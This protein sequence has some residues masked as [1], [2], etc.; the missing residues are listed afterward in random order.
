[1]SHVAATPGRDEQ[2]VLLTGSVARAALRSGGCGRPSETNAA[3]KDDVDHADHCDMERLFG[4]FGDESL[5]DIER[6]PARGDEHDVELG[7]SDIAAGPYEALVHGTVDVLASTP[8]VVDVV[9]GAEVDLPPVPGTVNR[10]MA[11]PYLAVDRVRFVGEPVAVVLTER[12]EQGPDAAELVV[13]DVD[14]LPPVVGTDAAL[15]D[16]TLLFPEVGTNLVAEAGAPDG[17]TAPDGPAGCF[18]RCCCCSSW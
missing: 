10:A 13:V 5:Y 18:R 15:A 4:V 17:A 9:V 2:R 7:F 16:E 11:R 14:P 6:V 1:M 3:I 12:P 8:G